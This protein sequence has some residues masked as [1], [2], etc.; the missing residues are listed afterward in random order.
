MLKTTI[1][2]LDQITS[3]ITI[4]L[5]KSRMI[6]LLTIVDDTYVKNPCLDGILYS[7]IDIGKRKVSATY[8]KISKINPSLDIILY[9]TNS[10]KK[11]VLKIDKNSDIIIL[12]KKFLKEIKDNSKNISKTIVY[13][14]IKDEKG[15]IYII[16]KPTETILEQLEENSTVTLENC[17]KSLQADIIGFFTAYE[18]LKYLRN[19]CKNN[20]LTI[21]DFRKNK[22]HTQT[23]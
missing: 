10:I 21:I 17:Y 22:I 6:N 5:A 3:S 14:V 18:A 8:E 20:I 9:E 4:A 23:Y 13:S 19:K 7:T 16:H 1:L 15:Y 11:V 2:G 12:S